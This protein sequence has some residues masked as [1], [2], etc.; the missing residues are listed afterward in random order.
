MRDT[1]RHVEDTRNIQGR[2]FFK[3][4]VHDAEEV[5]HK[6]AS[7][8][9]QQQKWH[10]LVELKGKSSQVLAGELDEQLR[11]MTAL[12]AKLVRAQHDVDTASRTLEDCRIDRVKAEQDHC[13]R[14]RLRAKRC[15]AVTF[16]YCTGLLNIVAF[17]HT[18]W[19]C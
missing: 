2:V 15:A 19:V 6:M 5:Q 8:R 10:N 17:G 3:D 1:C 7:A 9:Q 12:T 4:L 16:V 13:D 11:E 14:F 18:C